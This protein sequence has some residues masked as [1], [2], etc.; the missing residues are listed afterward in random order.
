MEFFHAGVH[1]DC[2]INIK[3]YFFQE[4]LENRA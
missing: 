2:N 3:N 1:A 4:N